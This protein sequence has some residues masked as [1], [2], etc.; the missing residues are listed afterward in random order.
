MSLATRSCASKTVDQSIFRFFVTPLSSLPLFLMWLISHCRLQLASLA[1]PD[2]PT[3]DQ[4]RR[5]RGGAK[6]ISS[7]SK[8]NHE[9][10]FVW[11]ALGHKPT[12]LSERSRVRLIT[13]MLS[14]F[15][16]RRM[17]SLPI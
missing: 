2:Q 10:L 11:R 8:L 5:R 1:S 17:A 3:A 4:R 6:V 12:L 16:L 7:M 9:R 13:L 15:F 14:N